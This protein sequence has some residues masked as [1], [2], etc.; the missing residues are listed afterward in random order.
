MKTLFLIL[1]LLLISN[2][3]LA[4][5]RGPV[6]TL[7]LSDFLG[8]ELTEKIGSQGDPTPYFNVDTGI[9]TGGVV[10]VNGGDSAKFDV[11]AGTGFIVDWADQDNPTYD[12][13]TWD[14]FTAVTVTGL[15][16]DAFTALTIDSNG[17]LM[18]RPGMIL[19]SA[20]QK[21]EIHIQGLSHIDNV[22]I[23]SIG[24]DSTP[25]YQS[26][27]A[28]L[29]YIRFTGAATKGNKF[30]FAGVNLD[31]KKTSGQSSLP[32][33]NRDNDPQ[34]PSVQDDAELDPVA[35]MLYSYD[36]GGGSFPISLETAIDPAN[37]APSGVLTAVTTNRWTSQRIRFF[38]QTSVVTIDYGQF[39]YNTLVAAQAAFDLEDH[40][41]DPNFDS[42]N[43]ITV[44]FV[45]QGATDLSNSSDAV[46][47]QRQ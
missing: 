11:S 26:M 4:R 19:S 14:A 10:T 44:L 30:T 23:D 12:Y 25:A 41:S 47:V 32:F 45:N 33:I 13:I 43:L 15:A 17:D 24:G 31:L 2:P 39:Q 37:Y 9:A 28:V 27:A 18:Q 40:T 7:T 35:S 1:S 36:A 29:D 6:E 16:T 22:S 5:P 8:E 38:P 20:Q 21:T 34:N 3:A 46:F 42:G